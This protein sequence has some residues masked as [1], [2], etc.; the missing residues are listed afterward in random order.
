[1]QLRRTVVGLAITIGGGLVVVGLT[2]FGLSGKGVNN[3][4]LDAAVSG[5]VQTAEGTLTHATLKLD[6]YPDSMA[7][8]HGTDGGAHP[9]W[10]ATD[11]STNLHVPAHSLVTV[12]IHQYDGGETITNP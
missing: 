5:T 7:G 3:L 12:T 9:D 11:P 6:T 1:M 8:E 10:V 4:R 2:A